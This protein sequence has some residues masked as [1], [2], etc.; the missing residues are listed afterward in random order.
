MPGFD[1]FIGQRLPVRLLQQFMRNG[2]IPHALLFTGI[3]GI[4][5]L[6]MAKTFAMALNC[7]QNPP[8]H[9]QDTIGEE[10]PCGKCPTCIKISNQRHPDVITLKPQ[11]GTL[12]ID[13]I[14]NL[15]G[16]LAMKPF[17]AEHRVVIIDEA[18]ALTPGAG[19]AL[20][21]V[22]EEPPPDTIIILI[23]VQKSDLLPT[24]V[25]RC[26]HIHFQPLCPEDLATLLSHH[27][28]LAPEQATII[29]NL[30]GGSY[31]KARLLASGKWQDMRNWLIQAVGLGQS[32]SQ[33]SAAI[34]AAMALAAQLAQRKD[35][36]DDL[37]DILSTWL[38]DLAVL[39]YAGGGVINAD[40]HAVLKQVRPRLNDQKLLG[41]WEAVQNAQKD[42]AANGNLRLTMEIMTLGLAGCTAHPT[43]SK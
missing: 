26:R 40:C 10:P 19:N 15:L 3:S 21:K 2:T 16:T 12:R 20:L 1:A 43:V 5:K 38:R 37:L 4:G 29:A 18:Q 11:K 17:S 22:L 39:P 27:Q 25:S 32:K 6:T 23:N 35:K 41:M 30:A 31:E 9:P 24:I 13:Q 7:R 8:D 33:G 28:G 42:I 34:T 14:R 36:I